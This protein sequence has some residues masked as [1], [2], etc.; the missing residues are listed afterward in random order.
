MPP[1]HSS[2]PHK[3]FFSSSHLLLFQKCLK[4]SSLWSNPFPTRLKKKK[5]KNNSNKKKPGGH[6]AL[7]ELQLK[8][9]IQSILFTAQSQLLWK[10]LISSLIS[11]QQQ[12]TVC[13]TS[14]NF[15]SSFNT[16]WNMNIC[17]LCSQ[18]LAHCN[19]GWRKALD[20]ENLNVITT[21]WKLVLVVLG[22]S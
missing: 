4:P 18:A 7:L 22:Y 10:Y 17:C 16:H 21:V 2:K 9:Y 14:G 11:L 19:K 12:T 13:D 15:G 8:S 5:K 6:S 3:I 1:R 20:T